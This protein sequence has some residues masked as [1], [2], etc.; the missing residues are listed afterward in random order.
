VERSAELFYSSNL[1]KMGMN[2]NVWWPD[3]SSSTK[4]PQETKGTE[5]FLFYSILF[6]VSPFTYLSLVSIFL[7]QSLRPWNRCIDVGKTPCLERSKP[8][9]NYRHRRQCTWIIDS[10]LSPSKLFAAISVSCAGLVPPPPPHLSVCKRIHFRLLRWQINARKFPYRSICW[11][12]A[13]KCFG[14]FVVN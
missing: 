9:T 4:R 14:V 6:I 2:K 3:K 10:D 11:R 12:K 1:L 7:G 8:L 13:D 5:I